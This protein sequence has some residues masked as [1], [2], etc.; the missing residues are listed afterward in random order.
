[1]TLFTLNYDATATAHKE[2]FELRARTEPDDTHEPPWE[3]ED[4]HGPVRWVRL[5]DFGQPA[6][7]P[8]ESVLISDRHGATVYGMDDATKLARKEGWDAEPYNTDKRETPRQQAAKAAKADF[9]R[10][11]AWCN[12]DWHYV[13]VIVE[14][15]REGIK[16]GS[17]SLWGIESDSDDYLEEVAEELADEAIE[18]AKAKLAS[19]CACEDA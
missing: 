16:L 7:E 5:N 2:G 4:G 6:K 19:I 18:E 11:K 14:A 13:G 8:G 10:L 12:D 9:E 3:A 17:A 15:Y 1:M